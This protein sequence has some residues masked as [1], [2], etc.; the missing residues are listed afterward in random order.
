MSKCVN[1][2][3][4][5]IKIYHICR[6]QLLLRF[7]S[8]PM[9][10]QPN[11]IRGEILTLCVGATVSLLRNISIRHGLVNSSV[12]TVVDII[13][14]PNGK[15]IKF[16]LVSFHGYDGS[17]QVRSSRGVGI[18]IFPMQNTEMLDGRLRAYQAIPLSL[19]YSCTG[20]R[21][22]CN[23]YDKLAIKL[24]PKTPFLGYDYLIFS[25]TKSLESILI[26][27]EYILDHRFTYH[28]PQALK[29]FHMNKQEEDRLDFLAATMGY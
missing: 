25:R 20:H 4:M 6:Q 21:T 29:F 23:T 13:M 10:S 7:P 19:R 28:S 17:I 9:I 11:G 27:D 3:R 1:L 26:L 22:Q 18:P 15:K 12:G 24:G 14:Q 5:L 8:E 16:V 2:Y